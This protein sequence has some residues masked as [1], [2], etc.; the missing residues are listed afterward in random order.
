LQLFSNLQKYCGE[1]NI[2]EL[3]GFR[4]KSILAGDLK[5][6][7]PVWNSKVSKPSGLKLLELFISNFENFS[8]TMLYAC[9]H[10][11]ADVMFSTSWYIRTSDRQ[12]SWNQII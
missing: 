12:T 11:M 1:T 10:L 2:T 6:K 7:H 9:I 4:N 5:A 3:L 8:S